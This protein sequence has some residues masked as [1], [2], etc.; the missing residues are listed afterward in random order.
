MDVCGVT[1]KMRRDRA[2]IAPS[3]ERSYVNHTG[4]SEADSNRHSALWDTRIEN[5]HAAP[6]RSELPQA[7]TN[8]GVNVL[9]RDAV[10]SDFESIVRLNTESEQFLN[11]QASLTVGDLKLLHAAASYHR[12]AVIDGTIAAFVLAF[13][14]GTSHNDPNYLWFSARFSDFLYVDRIIVGGASRGEGVGTFLYNDLFACARAWNVSRVTCEIDC[15]P[16]NE[17][18]SKFHNSFGFHEVGRHKVDDGKKT[19]SLQEAVL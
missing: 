16:P 2:C 12:V 17:I 8:H 10:E 18:S 5:P 1:E 9:I 11:S 14:G 19:V 6:P 15:D 3:S 7:P 4:A 13:R